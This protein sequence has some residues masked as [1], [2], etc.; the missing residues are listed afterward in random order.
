MLLIV[1][2][3][4]LAVGMGVFA[5]RRSVSGVPDA[6]LGAD[7]AHNRLY[8]ANMSGGILGWLGTSSKRSLGAA[9][10][11]ANRDGFEVVLVVLD[12]TNLLRNLLYLI[13][14]CLTLFIWC[15]AP[16]YLVIARRM[17]GNT[18]LAS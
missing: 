12:T 8:R 7:D 16:G 15:P 5:H 9:M 18:E 1:V 11:R 2:A 4:G 6:P 14:L 17:D 10:F 13:I 3:I